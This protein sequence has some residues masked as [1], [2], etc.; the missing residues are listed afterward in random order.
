MAARKAGM[1]GIEFP[2]F[3]D[4]KRRLVSVSCQ[5]SF[6]SWSGLYFGGGVDASDLKRETVKV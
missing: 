4:L 3:Q 5:S 2:H 6:F 1:S